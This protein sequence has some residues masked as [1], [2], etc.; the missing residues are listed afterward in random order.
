MSH[1][2]YEVYIGI[3]DDHGIESFIPNNQ[4]TDQD[5]SHMGLRTRFNGQ[6]NMLVYRVFLTPDSVQIIS[7]YL[8]NNQYKEALF[9]MKR[10]AIEVEVQQG[11]TRLWEEIPKFTAEESRELGRLLHDLYK[12]P[13]KPPETDKQLKLPI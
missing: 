12:K 1:P 9:V 10:L 5:V 11:H 4:V 6:R 13:S 7:N 2:K 3:A 8:A